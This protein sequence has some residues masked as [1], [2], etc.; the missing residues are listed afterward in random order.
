MALTLFGFRYSVYTRIARMAL[1][2]RGLEYETCEVNPFDDPP[3][4][5]LGEVT[6]FQRVPVLDHDGFVLFETSA[7]TRYLAARFPGADLVPAEPRAAAR[8]EQ[9]IAIVD[10]H[11]YWPMV[12]QVF[13]HSVF[14]P[15]LGEPVDESEIVDGLQGAKRVLAALEQIAN[16]GLVLDP[17]QVTL[18]DLH[19]APMVGYFAMA[20]QGR[21]ALA[22]YPALNRWWRDMSQHPAYVA[23]D[24][25]LATLAVGGYS[26][27]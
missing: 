4:Q 10:A 6:P 13:S 23:T 2:V 25:G 11:G 24:P 7:I 20:D 19:L 21:A 5:S 27:T 3:D 9:V 16:E 14:R 22:G 15:L 17:A 26:K 12:R 8:M 1:V 18:A